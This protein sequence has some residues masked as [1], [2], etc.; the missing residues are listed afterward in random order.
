MKQKEKPPLISFH[1]LRFHLG[2]IPDFRNPA[3]I[4]FTLAEILLLVIYCVIHGVYDCVNMEKLLKGKH[5][6]KQIKKLFKIKQVPSH[7]TISRALRNIDPQELTKA[8]FEGFLCPLFPVPDHIAI[9]GKGIRAAAEKTK[10]GKVPYVLNVIDA[11]TCLPLGQLAIPSK[12]NEIPQIPEIVRSLAGIR[13]CLI[14]TDAIGTQKEIIETIL[15]KG[16][17]YLLPVK[18]NQKTLKEDAYEYLDGYIDTNDEERKG[19]V[20]TA[21]MENRKHGRSDHRTVSVLSVQKDWSPPPGFESIRTVAL[22]ERR[23]Q[24]YLQETP[25]FEEVVYISN[26]KMSAEEILKRTSE[27][28]EIESGLHWTLDNVFNEDRMK[29]RRGNTVSNGSAI[30]KF[31]YG[32]ARLFAL[33]KDGVT[34]TEVM[35]HLRNNG[36]KIRELLTK[37]QLSSQFFEI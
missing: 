32:I 25:S 12:T 31:V 14:T 1:T 37:R 24:T 16:A 28:W 35:L 10:K 29:A 3:R 8:L 33:K 23:R 11:A 13:G 5:H 4:R 26:R 22:I 21:V 15:S 7:D 18:S 36:E 17:D 27:H 9:D 2:K 6:R 34:T 19:K 30:R 20:D